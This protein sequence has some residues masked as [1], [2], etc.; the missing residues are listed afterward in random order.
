MQN[1]MT[2]LASALV[3]NIKYCEVK[4]VF[5][6]KALITDVLAVPYGWLKDDAHVVKIKNKSRNKN[7]VLVIE[8][9]TPQATISEYVDTY[10]EKAKEDDIADYKFE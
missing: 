4:G 8:L 3:D 1:T 5:D 6:G 7:M 2:I 10:N 9:L